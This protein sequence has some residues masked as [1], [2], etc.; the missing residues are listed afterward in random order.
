MDGSS[1]VHPP[2]KYIGIHSS[3]RWLMRHLS[4]KTREHLQHEI[5][6]ILKLVALDIRQHLSTSRS[7]ERSCTLKVRNLEIRQFVFVVIPLSDL[8]AKLLKL[9]DA[10]MA[11]TTQKARMNATPRDAAMIPPHI[12][13]SR[14]I[15]VPSLSKTGCFLAKRS[16]TS[17]NRCAFKTAA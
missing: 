8:W 5:Q 4:R 12:E 16:R 3:P 17:T 15:L 14:T 13:M 10:K 11:L 1:D 9:A 7:Q 2:E 6:R